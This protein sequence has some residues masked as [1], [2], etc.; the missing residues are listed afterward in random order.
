MKKFTFLF[1]VFVCVFLLFGCGDE[2]ENNNKE[3]IEFEIKVNE[4]IGVNKSY[5]L[6]AFDKEGNKID[7]E[8]SVDDEEVASISNNQITGLNPGIVTVTAKKGDNVKEAF[9]VVDN[10]KT[11]KY[12]LDGGT[13]DN[14]EEEIFE[15]KVYKL[16]TPVKEGFTFL[17]WYSNQSFSGNVV[18]ELNSKNYS[19]TTLYASWHSEQYEI[20]YVLTSD[21][22]EEEIMEASLF[23]ADYSLTIPE[24]DKNEKVFSGWYLDKRLYEKVDTIPA[25]T[26][27]DIEVFGVLKD[28]NEKINITYVASDSTYEGG[29]NKDEVLIGSN[30]FKT[31]NR[32]DYTFLGWYKDSKYQYSAN[33]GIYLSSSLYAKFE[34]TYKVSEVVIK[35]TE[36]EIARKATLQLEYSLN[37]SK[38]TVNTVSYSSSDSSIASIS[39]TGLITALSKGVVTFAIKSRS[40]SGASASI[41]MEIYDNEYFNVSYET[42]SYV[43]KGEEIKLNASFNAR[44]T[45]DVKLKWESLNP[46]IASV[47]D[48]KVKGLSAGNG[49]IRVSVLDDSSKYFDFNVFVYEENISDALKF[50]LASHNSNVFTRYNLGI[51]AGTPAYYMDIIGSV[52]KILFNYNYQV[53][54]KYEAAQQAITSN[55]GGLKPSTEFITV[56]YTGN[57]SSGA[58]GAANA[59]YFTSGGNG[60]SI[61]YVTGNDGIFH[62]LDDDLIGFHAGDGHS[63]DTQCEWYPT[64]VMYQEGDSI[65]PTWGISE[66]SKYTLNGKETLIT[67]PTGS[68]PATQKVTDSKWIN[69]MG[70]GYKIVDGQYYMNKTWWC[71]TQISEGR[72]CNKGGNLNSV[73]IESAVNKGTDLWLTWQITAELVARLMVKY[74]LPIQRVVGHHFY[75]A[76]NCP[77]PHLENNLE[78]WWEFIELVKAEYERIT[79][80]DGYKFDFEVINGPSDNMGRVSDGNEF[81][82]IT[83]KV[84]I[85]NPNG[86][87]EEVTLSSIIKGQFAL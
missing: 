67:V 19:I 37:P 64:G 81:K 65:Y 33:D 32:T 6:E 50:V 4:Y 30:N 27:K 75:S 78:I 80:F 8:W 23:K 82:L 61:H 40:E 1:F 2:K 47:S 3:I 48:G 56:H 9:C 54:T 41:T 62:C 24:Y 34:E 39:S 68:T 58:S 69:K 55:H 44:L 10:V 49:V 20:K 72:L 21:N 11:I 15:S 84:T 71:Y 29:T 59:S 79:T 45:N 66:N 53:N 73:G 76:K 5:A 42:E 70:F 77:Q 14:L 38:V 16:P 43:L 26:T 60:T 36:T 7:V 28:K 17:G 63:D 25:G 57:M 35:N 87:K 51:G 83:Y 85:T 74:D 31:P 13:C 86:S 18:T 52:S 12:E 46:S 22:G